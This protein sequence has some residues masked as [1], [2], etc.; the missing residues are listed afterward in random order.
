[1]KNINLNINVM[2]QGVVIPQESSK[3]NP[4]IWA[5]L[6]VRFFVKL[7]SQSINLV[8]TP[9]STQLRKATESIL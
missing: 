7:N 3:L 9:I 4:R 8:S 5:S 2:I 6:F 1:M